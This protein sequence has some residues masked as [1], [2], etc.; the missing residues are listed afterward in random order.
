METVVVQEH[1]VSGQTD[2]V[3]HMT[4]LTRTFARTC[5]GPK[6]LTPGI[7]EPKLVRSVEHCNAP[8]AESGRVLHPVELLL[9]R[10]APDLHGGRRGDGPRQVLSGLRSVVLDDL[11]SGAVPLR[12]AGVLRT[13]YSVLR[14]VP[15]RHPEQDRGEHTRYPP[16]SG[17]E[18]LA[19]SPSPGERDHH[20]SCQ[21]WEPSPILRH[22]TWNLH[23]GT[24]RLS[25]VSRRALILEYLGTIGEG[26]DRIVEDLSRPGRLSSL[27]SGHVAAEPRDPHAPAHES[28]EEVDHV[29]EGK[30]TSIPKL[31]RRWRRPIVRTG[32]SRSSWPFRAAS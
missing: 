15:T 3:F 27:S 31:A 6:I 29:L 22:D 8:V 26:P 7:V 10:S 14:R 11:D 20:R 1:R 18:A 4:E 19:S 2:D 12:H 25:N 24:S 21:C 23:G 30:L 16:E 28:D 17:R 13:I 32:P 9:R 5:R